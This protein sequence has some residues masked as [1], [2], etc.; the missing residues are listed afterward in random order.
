MRTSAFF[1]ALP[2]LFAAPTVVNAQTS[3]YAQPQSADA[4]PPFVLGGLEEYRNRNLEDAVKIWLKGSA[5]EGMGIGRRSEE[6]RKFVENDGAFQSWEL[7]STRNYSSRFRILYLV[8]HFEKR[9]VFASFQIYQSDQGW[10]LLN[11]Y[12][13]NEDPDKILPACSVAN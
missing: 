2:L 12:A 4:I 5:S 7:M 6:L 8:L 11:N 13:F 3:G 10:I 1:L 9:P